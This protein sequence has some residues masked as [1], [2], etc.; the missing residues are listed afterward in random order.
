MLRCTYIYS[1]PTRLIN[2]PVTARITVYMLVFD[3]AEIKAGYPPL[4]DFA[5]TNLIKLKQSMTKSITVILFNV[6][7]D[8]TKTGIAAEIMFMNDQWLNLELTRSSIG[9]PIKR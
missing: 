4:K 7:N 1:F 5:R 2:G 8:K 9:T 6:N 3:I